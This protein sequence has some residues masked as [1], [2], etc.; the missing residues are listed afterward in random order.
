MEEEAAQSEPEGRR[1][2]VGQALE[3]LAMTEGEIKAKRRE[4]ASR[5]LDEFY[6]RRRE[7][8]AKR[9]AEYVSS[10][11]IPD[12]QKDDRSFAEPT[13]SSDDKKFWDRV[14][15]AVNL[16]AAGAEDNRARMRSLMCELSGAALGSVTQAEKRRERR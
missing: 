9:R 8:L 2:S 3:A 14:C 16:T 4:D 15:R 10:T 13:T 6:E 7:A 5:Q 12:G 11:Q 1:K